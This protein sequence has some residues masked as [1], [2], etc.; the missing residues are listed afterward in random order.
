MGPP[1]VVS[2]FSVLPVLYSS[3]TTHV[4]YGKAHA[5]SKTSDNNAL[6]KGRTLFLVNVPPFATEREIVLFF[7]PAGVVEKVIFD[8]R[9]VE[10]STLAQESESEEEGEEGEMQVDENM[11][12]GERPA[13]RRRRNDKQK[14]T[15]PTLIPLPPT[16]LRTL[17]KTG[18]TAYVVFL[19]PSSLTRALTPP[20]KARPWPSSSEPSG[21]S[22]YKALYMARRPALD[23]VREHAESAIALFDYEEEQ[24]KRKSQYKKGEA[25]VDED[26][27]TL[28]TR[29]GAYG[30]T[31]GGG[32]GVASKKFLET[33]DASASAKRLRKKKKEKKE[34]EGFYSFQKHEQKRQRKFLSL[35][36]L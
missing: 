36:L 5:G 32:V 9:E 29:G 13:R 22:H 28:V 18:R 1:H 30:Q 17:R 10:E 25:I 33:G 15:K 21:L 20:H 24:R 6:P 26:G 23:A 27:F 3:Q 4:L 34:K 16:S 7:K 35:T 2:G 31:V 11:P 8:L 12:E 19:D 14:E